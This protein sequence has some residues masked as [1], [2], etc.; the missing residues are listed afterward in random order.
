MG[1]RPPPRQFIDMQ[2]GRPQSPRTWRVAAQHGHGAVGGLMRNLAPQHTQPFGQDWRPPDGR[3]HAV[4]RESG[5][6]FVGRREVDALARTTDEQTHE[7]DLGGI[8][9][10][11]MATRSF[12]PLMLPPA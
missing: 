6:V 10:L 4:E 5:L 3:A 2:A 9:S 7:S 12:P 1:L 8:F 11:G